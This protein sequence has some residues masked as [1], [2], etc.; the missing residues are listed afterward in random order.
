MIR[1]IMLALVT[2]SVLGLTTSTVFGGIN[3][4]GALLGIMSIIFLVVVS[5]SI[6]FINQKRV[7]HNEI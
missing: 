7:H 6:I 3:I 5:S 1:I 4:D 2:G